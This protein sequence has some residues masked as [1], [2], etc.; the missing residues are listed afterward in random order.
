VARGFLRKG[1]LLIMQLIQK[2]QLTA[3]KIKNFPLPYTVIVTTAACLRALYLSRFVFWRAHSFYSGLMIC[4][5]LLA[6]FCF[7]VLRISIGYIVL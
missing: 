6:P 4:Y 7:F 1:W 5:I 2:P 3:R